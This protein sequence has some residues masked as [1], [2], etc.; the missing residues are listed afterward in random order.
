M[1]LGASQPRGCARRS[2]RFEDFLEQPLPFLLLFPGEDSGNDFPFLNLSLT[3]AGLTGTSVRVGMRPRL[4]RNCSASRLSKK[5]AP[6][7]AALGCGACALTP[8]EPKNSATGS[9]AQKSIA[10]PDSCTLT[11]REA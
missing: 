1:P 9:S 7:T 4:V 3:W 6:S 8:T 5:F 2:S 11:V 10:A